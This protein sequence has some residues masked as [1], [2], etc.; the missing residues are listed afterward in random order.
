MNAPYNKIR[1]LDFAHSFWAM[2]TRAGLCLVM[3]K[4][5]LPVWNGST[6]AAW[7]SP[8]STS[9]KQA[10]S[11]CKKRCGFNPWVGKIPWRRAWQPT[12]VFLPGESHEQ[13]SL[14]GYSPWRYKESNMTEATGHTRS[15]SEHDPTEETEAQRDEWRAQ[16]LVPG[17]SDA[18][19]FRTPDFKKSIFFPFQKMLSE[20]CNLTS[21]EWT[22]K[23][24]LKSFPCGTF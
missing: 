4:R 16:G 10:V 20:G 2:Q 11:Q 13:R 9:G 22:H 15:S 23:P 17:V 1:C 24:K 18:K 7:G 21:L 8:G 19:E 5:L 6:S 3:L 14:V 12:P